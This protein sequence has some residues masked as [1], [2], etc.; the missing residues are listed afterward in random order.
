MPDLTREEITYKIE[1]R[2]YS[3]ACL[4]AAV[5]MLKRDA[6]AVQIVEALREHHRRHNCSYT[7]AAWALSLRVGGKQSEIPDPIIALIE[8]LEGKKDV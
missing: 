1:H 6:P 7:D 3:A 2:S 4:N 8:R 5:E